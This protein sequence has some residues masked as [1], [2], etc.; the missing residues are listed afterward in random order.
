MA[1][2]GNGNGNGNGGGGNGGGGNP[3]SNWGMDNTNWSQWSYSDAL[4]AITG[5]T[6]DLWHLTWTP[7][8]P[9]SSSGK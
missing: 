4:A 7:T 8:T 1:G 6:V 3:T 5:D 2:N 9:P